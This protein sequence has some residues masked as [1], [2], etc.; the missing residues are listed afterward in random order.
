[1]PRR[2]NSPVAGEPNFHNISVKKLGEYRDL[3][4]ELIFAYKYCDQDKY[5]TLKEIWKQIS[6]K[7][8]EVYCAEA[9]AELERQEREEQTPSKPVVHKI[10]AVK[11]I[12][13]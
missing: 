1:M 13:R 6:D 10:K 9:I 3:I 4:Q 12:K 5:K 11:R 7:H 2:T 8:N